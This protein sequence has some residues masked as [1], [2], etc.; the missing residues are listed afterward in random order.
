MM[1]MLPHEVMV[2]AIETRDASFAGL[3]V[4]AVKST[5]IFCRPGCPARTPARNQME[6]FPGPKQA[7]RAGYRPCRRCRPTSATEAP[8]RLVE[9]LRELIEENPMK[10]VTQT[11]L[12]QVGIDPSTARRQFQKYYGMSFHNYQRSRKLGAALQAL[13]NGENVLNAGLDA[14]YD[15]V[16]GFRDAFRE[17]FGSV[18]SEARDHQFLNANLIETPIGAMLAI[19][20]NDALHLLE[21]IDRRRLLSEIDQI[22]KEINAIVVPG[23][24]ELLR[25][26]GE[27]LSDYFTGKRKGFTLPLRPAGTEF[28]Q[29]VWN[30]LLNIPYGSTL[31]YGE[32]GRRVGH[33]R[34][35]RAIGRANGANK[36]AIVIPCHRVIR[37]D[38]TL[39]GY[40]GG[41]WRKKWLLVHEQDNGDES[42]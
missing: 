24:N 41:V 7:L 4:V 23:E 34:A 30:E 26:V 11:D 14:G 12:K 8:P 16:S 29:I 42:T 21:F 39:S 22:R 19:A 28:E 1:E 3:F 37:S 18:P 6:F 25:Q 13:R 36:L 40:G 17:V 35:A 9:Q 10:R 15:S 33:D 20:D 31:S 27:E 32:L 2:K 5:G 38:G